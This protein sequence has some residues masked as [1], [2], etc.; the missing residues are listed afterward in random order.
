MRDGARNAT[1]YAAAG[2]M[3]SLT[4]PRGLVREAV[5]NIPCWGCVS[6]CAIINCQCVRG[7]GHG[8]T[9]AAAGRPR[10]AA[11]R[12][13][14]VRLCI[15]LLEAIVADRAL[16]ADVPAAERQALILAAGRASRPAR[17]EATRLVKEFRAAQEAAG[18]RRTTAR[19]AP[20]RASAPRAQA[21]VFVAPAPARI[22]ARGRGAARADGP[23]LR[24]P[25][26]CYVCKT[27]FTPPALLLRRAVP[28]LRG[29]QLRQALPDR[30]ARRPGGA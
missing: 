11:R 28:G 7:E 18:C 27:E 5:S 2:Q 26:S 17:H 6:T 14:D 9:D 29:V 20:P 15:A 4:G 1:S 24:K 12:S 23:T 3:T 16:L 8:G 30:A 25:K 22:A 19:R 10:R 21:A 13:S